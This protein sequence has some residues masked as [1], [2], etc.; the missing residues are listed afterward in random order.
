MQSS[1]RV[2]AREECDSESLVHEAEGMLP[3]YT[4]TTLTVDIFGVLALLVCTSLPQ[5]Y[6][7][8][9]AQDKRRNFKCPH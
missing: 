6:S 1:K 8:R 7:S 5:K 9:P 3:S 2:P 4:A